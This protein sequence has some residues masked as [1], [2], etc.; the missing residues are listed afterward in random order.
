[1][2]INEIEKTDTKSVSCKGKEAPYDHPHI[3][4]EINSEI[5]H[6]DCPYCGKKFELN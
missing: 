5:G 2:K 1:M 3:Y 4:L 6:I